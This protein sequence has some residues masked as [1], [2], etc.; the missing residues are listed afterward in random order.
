MLAQNQLGVPVSG[1]VALLCL[2]TAHKHNAF[3]VALVRRELDVQ[4][5]KPR[6]RATIRKLAIKPA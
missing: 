2:V 3:F 4:I 1:S 5:K 6:S